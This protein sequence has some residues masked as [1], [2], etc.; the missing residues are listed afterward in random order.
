MRQER[1]YESLA[2]T[3]HTKQQEQEKPNQNHHKLHHSYECIEFTVKENDEICK[4]NQHV[5]NIIIIQ[6]FEIFSIPAIPT[7][8]NTLATS[9]TLIFTTSNNPATITTPGTPRL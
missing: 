9:T 4:P 3:S 7:I 1:L 6:P 8:S 5:P 2:R